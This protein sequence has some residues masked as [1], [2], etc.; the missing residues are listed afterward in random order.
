ME[1]RQEA[2][3]DQTLEQSSDEVTRDGCADHISTDTHDPGHP[4]TSSDALQYP[5]WQVPYLKA[6]LEF[7]PEK[8]GGRIADAVAAILGRLSQIV[9]APDASPE[10]QAI[11]DALDALVGLTRCTRRSSKLPKDVNLCAAQTALSPTEVYPQESVKEYLARIGIEG[12]L[13]DG[14]TGATRLPTGKRKTGVV[15]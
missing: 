9:I 10:Q 7:D 15:P 2:N 5:S 1:S 11:N 14:K 13:R 12:G 6:L 3:L 8:L 4:A